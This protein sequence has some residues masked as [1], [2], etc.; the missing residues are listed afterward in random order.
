MRVAL[1]LPICTAVA[2]VGCGGNQKRSTA[3]PPEAQPA[4][5][6]QAQP[7][8]VTHVGRSDNVRAELVRLARGLIPP[9]ARGSLSA[10]D[11][12]VNECSISPTFP[13]ID[14]FFVA[15]ER[16]FPARLATLRALAHTRGWRVE[17]VKRF[18]IGK[19]S[20]AGAY[21]GLARGRFHARYTLANGLSGGPADKITELKIFG[22]P[23]RVAGPST[24]EK[25]TWSTEKRA[26]VAKANA[27]CARTLSRLKNPHDVA[28]AFADAV[29]ALGAL[30]RPTG[31]EEKV[32]SF[33]RPLR[34][35]ATAAQALSDGKG[36]D[37]LPAVVAVGQSAKRFDKAAK[38]YG[39]DK[40]VF[41]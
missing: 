16:R 21:L 39:L 30:R 34:T 22:P 37:A 10:S 9:N 4:A 11:L 13:C 15:H 17:Q 38:R 6:R 40:C 7:G 35:L 5:G 25:N 31:D 12:K 1:A 3:R 8:Q 32:A 26:Y 41:S 27:V 14:A 28:P 2:L 24:K 23:T 33:L 19:R 36:E 20:G 29:K 18:G